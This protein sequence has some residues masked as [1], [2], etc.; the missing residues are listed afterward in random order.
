MSEQKKKFPQAASTADTLRNTMHEAREKDARWQDGKTFSMVFYP[1]EEAARVQEEAYRQFFFENGLNPSA[2][3][4]LRKFETEV[5][6]MSADL[7]NGDGE[8]VGNMT[9]GGTESI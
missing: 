2:F 6:A 8:V 7:V 3:P 5:V 9:S 4:S 1:G